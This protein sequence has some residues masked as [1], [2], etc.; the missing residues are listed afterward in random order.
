MEIEQPVLRARVRRFRRPAAVIAC[1]SVAGILAISGCSSSN[2]SSGSAASATGSSSPAQSSATGQLASQVA[3]AKQRVAQWEKPSTSILLNTPLSKTPPKGLTIAYITGDIAADEV[4][5][6]G[7]DNVASD[8][9]W[10]PAVF[11]YDPANPQT[12]DAAVQQAVAHKVDYIVVNSVQSSAFPQGLAAAKAAHIPIIEN[13][14][15]DE[16]GM[17]GNGIDACVACNTMLDELQQ[18]LNDWMIQD[19]NGAGNILLVN[20]P[21]YESSKFMATYDTNYFK[22]NCSGCTFSVLSVSIQDFAGGQVPSVVGAYLQTHPNVTYVNWSFGALAD[23]A[24]QAL[25]SAGIG[26]NVKF[27]TAV[28]DQQTEQGLLDGSFSA[29]VPF[30]AVGGDYQAVDAAARLS[31]G[32]SVASAEKAA[33]PTT[34]WT[35]D[36][37]PKTPSAVWNGPTNMDQQYRKLWLVS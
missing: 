11:T 4:T 5:A 27:V 14:D 35:R 21:D 10:K 3:A 18:V 25:S 1:L 29:A 24:R 8:L 26:K 7:F 37:A 15:V 6:T 2:S 16:S 36:N 23:G 28:T 12:I 31:V 33:S 32:D 22:E 17:P 30:S 20:V 19:S 13:F 34:L 9:G